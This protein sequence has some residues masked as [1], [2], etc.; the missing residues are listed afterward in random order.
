MTMKTEKLLLVAGVGLVVYLFVTSQ[1]RASTARPTTPS[2][3]APTGPAAQMARE[4]AGWYSV[5][6][7][8]GTLGATIRNALGVGGGSMTNT[9]DETARLAARYPA[10]DDAVPLNLPGVDSWGFEQNIYGSILTNSGFGT[11]G[12]TLNFGG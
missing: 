4:Q 6:A 10:P 7:T 12:D 1:A 8:L 3:G 9:G 5:G 2:A 11:I